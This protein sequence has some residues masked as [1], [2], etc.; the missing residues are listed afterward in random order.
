MD[1]RSSFENKVEN[2]DRPVYVCWTK[3]V[4]GIYIP[5]HPPHRRNILYDL[6]YIKLLVAT[7]IPK[8]CSFSPQHLLEASPQ[9]D[10]AYKQKKTEIQISKPETIPKSKI[11]MP[12]EKI[13]D[14][15]KRFG[16]QQGFFLPN[17]PCLSLISPSI[18]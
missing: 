11:T 16:N 5:F 7:R 2:L 18:P 4:E 13:T 9:T 1:T 12:L 3:I 6:K 14:Y 17:L 8:N 10:E 15:D